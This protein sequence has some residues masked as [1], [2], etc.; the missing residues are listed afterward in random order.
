MS[1]TIKVSKSTL[2]KLEKFK[3]KMGVKT[4]EEVILRLI[5]EKRREL[6][7]RFFGID[8]GKISRFSEE[9]RLDSHI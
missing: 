3:V 6:V 5:D 1:T 2:R 4:F 7:E 8:K 9:D